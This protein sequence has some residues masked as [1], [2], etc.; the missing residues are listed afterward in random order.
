MFSIRN[1]NYEKMEVIIFSSLENLNK[2]FWLW[3]SLLWK[4]DGQKYFFSFQKSKINLWLWE[5]ETGSRKNYSFK[6][7]NFLF[8]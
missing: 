5:N 8:Q 6:I 4:N 2:P 7:A 3:E 1:F